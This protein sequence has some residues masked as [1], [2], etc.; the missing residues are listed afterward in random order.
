MDDNYKKLN[1]CIDDTKNILDTQ[2]SEFKEI[3][4]MNL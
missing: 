3:T 2:L 1:S 4:D